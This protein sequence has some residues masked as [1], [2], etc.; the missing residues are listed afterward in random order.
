MEFFI[1]ML[2]LF[3]VFGI[4]GGEKK[5]KAKPG[6]TADWSQYDGDAASV[7]GRDDSFE[8]ETEF[9][10]SEGL[11]ETLFHLSKAR[12]AKVNREAA[13]KLDYEGLAQAR[14]DSVQRF[15]TTAQTRRAK[16]KTR[17]AKKTKNQ[18]GAAA[19][20]QAPLVRDM[21][22]QRRLFLSGGSKNTFGERETKRGGGKSV[23]VFA[24][25][26]V[27]ALYIARTVIAA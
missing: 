8:N 13:A 23:F 25:F 10:Q 15:Q 16:N 5:K 17:R 21:N 1:F 18:S 22:M 26:G 9:E 3:V 11:S 2:F 19:A 6:P 27:L 20:D 24:V 14:R 7:S 4:L 12:A